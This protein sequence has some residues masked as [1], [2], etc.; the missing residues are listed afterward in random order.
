MLGV[1][2]KSQPYSPILIFLPDR[3]LRRVVGV[4]GIRPDLKSSVRLH[5]IHSADWSWEP[6]EEPNEEVEDE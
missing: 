4:A 6:Q 1:Q 3:K 5:I 2:A